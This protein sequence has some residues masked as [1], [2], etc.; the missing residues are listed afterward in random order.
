MR[1]LRWW[2]RPARPSADADLTPF[3][4]RLRAHRHPDTF[5]AVQDWVHRQREAPAAE[6]QPHNLL[7]TMKASISHAGRMRL[8][9]ASVLVLLLVVACNVPVE[10]E[11][12]FG[13]VLSGTIDQ[14]MGK[15]QMAD[16]HD[17]FAAQEAQISVE[18]LLHEIKVDD[19]V[20]QRTLH[21]LAIPLPEAS[22]SEAYARLEDLRSLGVMDLSI[23]PLE[24]TV[25][26]PAYKAALHHVVHGMFEIK[27]DESVVE[28]TIHGHLEKLEM[29]GF[30]V[31]HETDEHGNRTLKI[32]P[33]VEGH[34]TPEGKQNLHALMEEV[35]PRD[36]SRVFDPEEE[37]RLIRQKMEHASPEERAKMQAHLDKLHAHLQELKA[38]PDH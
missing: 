6:M 24:T 37:A 23:E 20:T 3:F 21:R 2:R 30:D 9:L 26:R 19:A 29:S 16:L 31:S 22:E 18:P 27:V 1:R 25:E 32:K 35:V 28:E 14:N 33:L 12:T 5:G 7:T 38:H 17:L 11:E 34:F 15:A 13:Y 36:A 4:D 10:Q 8:T